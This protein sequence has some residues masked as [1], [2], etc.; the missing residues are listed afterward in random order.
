[1][2]LNAT[3]LRCGALYYNK[4]YVT[5][6]LLKFKKYTSKTRFQLRKFLDR[7]SFCVTACIQLSFNIL[8]L[9]FYSISELK[10]FENSQPM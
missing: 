6:E 4:F 2:S 5:F 1:M 7:F 10:Q 8:I 3:I 9:Q